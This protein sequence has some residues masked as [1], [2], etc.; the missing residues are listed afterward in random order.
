MQQPNYG[1]TTPAPSGGLRKLELNGCKSEKPSFSMISDS[2]N[3]VVSVQSQS[4]ESTSQRP[5]KNYNAS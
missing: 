2:N 3:N 5:N 1:I 4:V